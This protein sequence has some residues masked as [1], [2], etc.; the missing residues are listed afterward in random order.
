MSDLAT[1]QS[2][3]KKKN[4]IPFG[5]IIQSLQDKR[6]KIPVKKSFNYEKTSQ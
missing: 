1:Q 6:S 2:K 4:L 3:K 5:N